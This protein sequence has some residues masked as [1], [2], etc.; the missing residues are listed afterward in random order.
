[1]RPRLRHGKAAFVKSDTELASSSSFLRRG[2]HLACALRASK[3]AD[4]HKA[5]LAATLHVF[6]L[7]QLVMVG[8]DLV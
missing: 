5:E 4:A 8:C 1:M 6:S 7:L 2:F 3:A